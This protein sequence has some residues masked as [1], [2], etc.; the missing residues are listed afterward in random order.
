[1]KRFFL[2]FILAFLVG[3]LVTRQLKGF[4]VSKDENIEDR[5]ER[6][7]AAVLFYGNGCPHCGKVEEWL[8]GHPEIKE[9]INL[10]EKEVYDDNENARE[11]MARAKGCG[12]AAEGGG[13]GV[14]F[15]Y[16]QGQCLM[17]DQPIINYLSDN[18]SQ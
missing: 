7:V 4:G 2:F 17:G 13:I 16:D 10:Q 8:E 1:M 11:L 14:P 3:I 5:K 6:K 12:I 18:Y 15:L 9:K